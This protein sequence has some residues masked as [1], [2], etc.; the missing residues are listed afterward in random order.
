MSYNI[1]LNEGLI[2]IS[3]KTYVYILLTLYY[4]RIVL[5]K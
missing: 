1:N 5:Y 2:K 3:N 4:K